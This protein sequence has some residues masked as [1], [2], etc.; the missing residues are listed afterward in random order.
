MS[1]VLATNCT[2]IEQAV[3]DVPAAC[4]ALERV[5]G[6][7]PIEEHVVERITGVVLDIDHR[8][9]GQAVFQFCR[10][11]IE[12]IP[13]RHELDRIGP[14]VTNLTFYVA[15]GAAAA[16]ELVAAGATVRGHWKTSG[17]PW[18]EHMGPGNARRPEDLADGWFMGT[19]A[20]FGFDFEF[21]EVP[22]LD[23][24]KQQYVYPAFTQPRPPDRGRVERLRRLKVLVEDRDRYLDNLTSLIDR[25]SRSEVYGLIDGPDA[26]RGRISLRGLELEYVE[27]RSGPDLDLLETVGAGIVTAVFGVRDLEDWP[28]RTF[29]LRDI[30]GLDIEIE[31]IGP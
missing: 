10:P 12:D 30:A 3:W 27:P 5:V 28:E 18:L 15:D 19:R 4:A 16:D 7:V 23:G 24:T 26:R 9:A 29:A 22:W 8:Q 6:A 14:C 17:G 31:T 21:S 25:G 1:I 20:L 11:L 2:Q 13:A